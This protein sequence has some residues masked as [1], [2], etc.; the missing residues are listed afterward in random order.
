MYESQLVRYARV[1][2]SQAIPASPELDDAVDLPLYL[3]NQGIVSSP[4]G[5]SEHS[6]R[7]SLHRQLKMDSGEVAWRVYITHLSIQAMAK[8]RL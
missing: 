2:V 6:D 7:S 8:R 5:G 1:D 4:T 3:P